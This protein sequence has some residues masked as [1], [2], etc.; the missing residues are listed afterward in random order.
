MAEKAVKIDFIVPSYKSRTLTSLAIRSF[1][2][3][4]GNFKFRYIV[5]ENAGDESYKEDILSLADEVVW[6][7]NKQKSGYL[8]AAANAEAIESGLKHIES[9]LVFI[10]HNDTIACSENWMEYL[11]G[12]IKDGCSIAG[13]VRDNVRIGAVHIS[14]MLLTAELAKNVS[15]YPILPTKHRAYLLGLSSQ[16]INEIEATRVF[17]NLPLDAELDVGDTYTRYCRLNNLKYFACENTENAE[18]KLK[19][20]YI[21]WENRYNMRKVGRALDDN[22]NIIF[23]HLGRGIA[24]KDNMYP[25]P[26]RATHDQWEIFVEEEIL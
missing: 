9:D 14:G 23:M 26:G 5:V 22:G 13:T 3:Y 11:Y 25:K 2:K 1:E 18:V 24:K 19:P 7:A 4:K 20:K 8:R 10:C 16:K 15:C 6:V 21:D 17:L 12:K